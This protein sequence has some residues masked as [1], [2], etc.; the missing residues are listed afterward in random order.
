MPARSTGAVAA[1]DF[2]RIRK[3]IDEAAQAKAVEIT[4]RRR[5]GRGSRWNVGLFDHAHHIVLGARSRGAN[6]LQSTAG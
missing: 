4:R 3:A 2:A 5:R 1:L 6:V